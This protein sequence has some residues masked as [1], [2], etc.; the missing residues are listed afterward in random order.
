MKSVLVVGGTGYLGGRLCQ[1]LAAQG[2]QITAVG[3]YDPADAYPDWRAAMHRVV[4]GDIR[5]R[6]TWNAFADDRFDA[7]ISLISLDH[8]QSEAPPE[9]VFAVNTLPSWQLL[10]MFAE[11]GLQRFIYFSTQ[12][13][14]GPLPAEVI[15]EGFSPQP[16]NKYGLTHLLTEQVVDFYRQTKGVTGINVRLSNGY[17]PPVFHANKCW[18]YV[19]MELCQMAY[20]DQTIRLLSDG[21]PLRDFVDLDDVCRSVEAMLV[22]DQVEPLY[23]LASGKTYSILEAAHLIQQI[24]QQRYGIRAPVVLADGSESAGATGQTDVPRYRLSIQRLERLGIVPTQDMP[25]GV[26]AIFDYLDQ[27]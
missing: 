22:S 12:Q 2:Y 27:H 10:E 8:S 23:H 3:R 20:Q 18:Q 1:Y 24:Y 6:E 16:R 5:E 4:I 15:D 7:I 9:Q 25:V 19:V 13:V 26:N 11:R 14:L 17:G 21:S